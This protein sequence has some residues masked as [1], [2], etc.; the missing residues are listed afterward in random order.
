MKKV[1][2][3]FLIILSFLV[4]PSI[5]AQKE[6]DI[7]TA[8]NFKNGNDVV[9]VWD[10]L[11]NGNQNYFDV[12]QDEEWI[13]PLEYY[14]KK[15]ITDKDTAL[16]FQLEFPLAY[17]YHTTTRFIKAVP[18]LEDLSHK[19]ARFSTEIYKLILQK[20]EESYVRSGNLKTGMDVR[21]RRINEG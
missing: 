20:L 17:L 11:T 3:K 14:Y 7:K 1:K 5:Y 19:K 9:R 4:W 21:K 8:F 15:A 16:Q 6:G 2:S 12:L 18:L 10:S 13:P